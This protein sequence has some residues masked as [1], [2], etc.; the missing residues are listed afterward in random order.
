MAVSR[1]K[2]MPLP[3]KRADDAP[4]VVMPP[5]ATKPAIANG[6]GN[7]VESLEK[8]EDRFN[9]ALAAAKTLLNAG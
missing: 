2:T 5:S 7:E 6:Q 4:T 1:S 3:E 8:A 9:K